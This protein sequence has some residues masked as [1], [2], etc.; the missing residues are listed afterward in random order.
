MAPK[1]DFPPVRACLFDVDGLLLN[2]E[3]L[4]TFCV[5]LVLQKY[6]RA[7]LPWSIKAKLQG[8][9]APEANRI[10]SDWA[11]LP[12][13]DAQYKDEL[14]AF[15]TNHFPGAKPL[16][17]VRELLSALATAKTCKNEKVHMAL[18]TSSHAGN[19]ALK[20]AHLPDVFSVFPSER[21]V[22]GDDSRLGP[23]RGKPLPDI[24]LLAL[25]T[26]NESLGPDERPI[27]TEECLVFE[28]SI[29]GVEAGRR[30]GMRVV[31]VPHPRLKD[32]VIGREEYILAGLTGEAGPVHM[33]KLGEVDDGWAEELRTLVG[34]PFEKYGIV[35]V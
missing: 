20:T 28:D 2:T 32:E 30:A 9:P 4:Y 16:P 35:P 18:A 31:W 15:Q 17:G 3:D 10:F 27:T 23:G 14:S 12:I 26:I 7:P 19:F 1:T 25:K 29:P 8:R 33:H 22:L 24:F 34:F 5:N 6:N 21:R 13:S 11:K